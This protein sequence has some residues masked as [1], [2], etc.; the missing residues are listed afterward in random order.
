MEAWEECLE[1]LERDPWVH[2]WYPRR[3]ILV[4]SFAPRYVNSFVSVFEA[5]SKKMSDQ[6]D[7][8]VGRGNI[9]CFDYNVSYSLIAVCE[10]IFGETLNTQRTFDRTFFNA[11]SQCLKYVTDRI[12]KP[13]LHSDII[14]KLLPMYA[15]QMKYTNIVNQCIDNM[16]YAKQEL[17]AKD[18]AIGKVD[19]RIK[20]DKPPLNSFLELIIKNSKNNSEKGYTHEELREE[21][22]VLA[23]AGSDTSAAGTSFT[24]LMLAQHPDVQDNVY[25]EIQDILGDPNKPLEAKDLIKLKYTTAVIKESLRLYPPISLLTRHCDKDLE[26]PSGLVLPA[27]CDVIIN[28]LGVHRNPDYWG[29][30]ANEFKPERFISGHVPPNGFIP[31]SQGAR[32][33]VGQQ[34]AMLSMTTVIVT[35][36]RR[37]R[38]KPATNVRRTK[39]NQLR[40]TFEVMTKEVNHFAIQVE[41]R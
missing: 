28:I 13:W 5:Q 1:T 37:Y 23:V 40:L 19:E 22:I 25:K 18:D 36:L 32:N 41:R 7:F 8:K 10:T 38:L 12:T 15:R 9:G 39:H 21:I 6:L 2:I 31:F 4:P 11:F 20:T 3:K 24:M 33:C 35:I 16:I 27:G 14:Y 26:L 29:E 30:D 34:Y 17:L